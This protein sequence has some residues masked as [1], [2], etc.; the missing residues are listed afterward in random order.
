MRFAK[1]LITCGIFVIL[2]FEATEFSYAAL[3]SSKGQRESLLEEGSI[4]TLKEEE[5]AFSFESDS[6]ARYIPRESVYSQQGKLGII[7]TGSEQSIKTK[8]FGVLPVGFI[9][10][11]RYIGIENSTGVTLPASLTSVSL[12]MEVT[13]PFFGIDKTYSF[14]GLYPSWYD[15]NWQCRSASFRTPFTVLAIRKPNERLTLIAGVAAFPEFQ[16]EVTPV[17]GFRYLPN[18]RLTFDLIPPKPSISYKLNKEL[19]IFAEG[20]LT[21][22]EYNVK[23]DGNKSEILKYEEMNLGGGFSYQLGKNALFSLSAGSVMSHR[24]KYKD[25]VGKIR[26]KNGSYVNLGVLI[27]I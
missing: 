4:S 26:V 23:K 13:G 14:I 10:G 24:L 9:V 7:D 5:P 3:P 16:N 12:G 11:A 25:Y 2:F 15:S 18:D 20:G 22:N 27:K 6:F 21:N 8:A 19:S 1:V 17:I